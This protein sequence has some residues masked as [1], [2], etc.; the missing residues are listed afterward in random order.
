M[1][2][3]QRHLIECHCVLP[4]Y[5]NVKPAVYHKFPVYSNFDKNEKV[6]PKYVNCNNCGI[7]HFVYELCKSEIKVGKE[8][9]GSVRSINDISINFS[10]R[11]KNILKE[12]ECQ[13][14]VYEELEDIFENNSFPNNIILKR[15][16]VEENYHLKIL[17]VQSSD[18]FKIQSEVFETVM[19]K[20][21]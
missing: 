3:G 4:I 7:T 1:Q 13:V 12:Y 6:I 11:L 16:I 2:K 18:K 9:I 21:V 5:K 15:E 14:D 19:I 20:G 10:E 17:N 8:D